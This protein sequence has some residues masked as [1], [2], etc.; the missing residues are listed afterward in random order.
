MD[1]LWTPRN[2]TSLDG[3]R[4]KAIES[5][6]SQNIFRISKCL[7]CNGEK[8]LE[9]K[10]RNEYS[11]LDKYICKYIYLYYMRPEWLKIKMIQ[12]TQYCTIVVVVFPTSGFPY[13]ILCPRQCKWNVATT[14]L[15]IRTLLVNFYICWFTGPTKPTLSK[16]KKAILPIVGQLAFSKSIIFCFLKKK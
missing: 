3:L 5:S 14:Y 9:D 12:S 13:L 11:L 2:I 1:A 16:N 15:P 7:G 4:Y 6:I 8:S 10:K